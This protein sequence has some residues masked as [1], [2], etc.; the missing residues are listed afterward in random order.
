MR[1]LTGITLHQFEFSHFNEKA[2]WALAYKGLEHERESYLP[3]PH[4]GPIRK[5]SGQPQTPV[6]EIDGRV[7]SGSSA[8]VEALEMRA[9]DPPLYPADETQRAEALELQR[10]FDAE[11]GPAVRC[12]LF[13][14]S[15]GEPGYMCRMFARG[16]PLPVRALYRATFPLAT[17][18]IR[19]GN[20]VTGREAID[21]AFAATEAALD[22]VEERT[23]ATGY[24]VG[25][26]F[27]VADLTA[28]ALLAPIASPT[29]PD[30]ARPRPVPASI[31]RLL[32]RWADRPAIRWVGEQYAKHRP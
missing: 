26:T 21:A 29:H 15:L 10:H 3:G 25:D 16:K 7:V 24:L 28:A 14:V 32:Q 4:V 2:R 30:M 31:E 18:L 13:S 17:P 1:S 9:P 12:A 8:I 27:T 11:V 22:L 5:L 6:L 23:A 20:G 19:K